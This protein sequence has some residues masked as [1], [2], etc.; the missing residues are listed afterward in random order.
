MQLI[1]FMVTSDY[2]ISLYDAIKMADV[3]ISRGTA[4]AN[5]LPFVDHN[6]ILLGALTIPEDILFDTLVLLYP[7]LRYNHYLISSKIHTRMY[8]T[9]VKLV[10]RFF[11]IEILYFYFGIQFYL[12]K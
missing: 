5:Y 11:N 1:C 10:I 6:L 3:V 9:L 12:H 7:Y 8:Y 2:L 4:S